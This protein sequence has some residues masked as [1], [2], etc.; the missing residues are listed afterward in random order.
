MDQ[1][2]K[3]DGDPFTEDLEQL[4]K[5]NGEDIE[6]EFY[7]SGERMVPNQTIYEVL[8]IVENKARRTK[9]S[10]L[11]SILA[12]LQGGDQITVHFAIKDKS[13]NI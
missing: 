6:F 7:V 10:G 9:D 4:I 8:K 1:S 2:I 3:S 5:A 11:G 13:D 12:A